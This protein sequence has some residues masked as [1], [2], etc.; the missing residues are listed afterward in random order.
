MTDGFTM[1][2][3]MNENLNPQNQP[4]MSSNNPPES[5]NAPVPTSPLALTQQS[6]L[7]ALEAQFVADRARAVANLNT[8]MNSP[9]GVAEHP[10]VIAEATTLLK[11]ID[12]ADSCL[13]TMQRIT[14]QP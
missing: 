6:I 9:V 11:A 13:A 10:D 12:A 14:T 7:A 3:N 5:P 2:D 4:G 8:Y 1:N